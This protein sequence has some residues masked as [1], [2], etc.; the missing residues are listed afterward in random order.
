MEKIILLSNTFPVSV[1]KY[2][3]KIIWNWRIYFSNI[4]RLQWSLHIDPI[5]ASGL[6]LSDAHHVGTTTTQWHKFLE[7]LTQRTTIRTKKL[8]R[9]LLVSG[10]P[11]E[12]PS[13]FMWLTKEISPFWDNHAFS[14]GHE[15]PWHTIHSLMAVA[16]SGHVIW[17]IKKA[18]VQKGLHG[19]KFRHHHLQFLKSHEQGIEYFHFVLGPTTH[20]AAPGQYLYKRYRHWEERVG[21][22][23]TRALERA[24]GMTFV[25]ITHR[26]IT[27]HQMRKWNPRDGVNGPNSQSPKVGGALLCTT[28]GGLGF[29]RL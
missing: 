2:T 5:Q 6:P 17:A 1:Q 25:V 13:I 15:F 10:F 12:D 16:A 19:L 27:F 29:I 28:P 26:Q 8:R 18:P 3:Q 9:H 20:A 21:F 22:F 14:N 11:S 7:V 23:L 4:T 24:A